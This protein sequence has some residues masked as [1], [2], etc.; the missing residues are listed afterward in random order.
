MAMSQRTMRYSPIAEWQGTDALD[1]VLNYPMY[2]ALRDAYTLPGPANVSELASVFEQSKTKFAVRGFVSEIVIK[3]D[4]V[5]R[6]PPSLGTSWK[7]K[8]SRD[9][10]TCPWTHRASSK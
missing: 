10:I 1:S 3:A 4:L 8:M 5:A 6:I 7:I 9:G 2:T